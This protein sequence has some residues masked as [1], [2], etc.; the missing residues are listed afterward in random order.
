[1]V[2]LKV[3]SRRHGIVV[4]PYA[5][6]LARWNACANVKTAVGFARRRAWREQIAPG[7]T[8]HDERASEVACRV[9][10][11]TRRLVKLVIQ[12]VGGRCVLNPAGA[13]RSV[14]SEVESDG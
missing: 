10:T 11:A 1:M 12:V 4:R 3:H 7:R 6:I 14:Q 2:Y 13:A 5:G 8:P 9:R